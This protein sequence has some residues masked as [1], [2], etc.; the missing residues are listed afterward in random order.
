MYT[1][2]YFG[3]VVFIQN[4]NVLFN[5]PALVYIYSVFWWHYDSVKVMVFNATFNNISAI[6]LRS[7]LL[8]LGE[9]FQPKHTL[10]FTFVVN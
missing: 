10:Y 6:S 1:Y 2:L 4:N 8:V 7:D 9:K 5:D 3:G